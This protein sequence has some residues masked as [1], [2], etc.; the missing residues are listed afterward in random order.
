MFEPIRSF[1][2]PCLKRN[3]LLNEYQLPG[4]T[5][6]VYLR[7]KSMDLMIMNEVFSHRCY[8]V[9]M[10]RSSYFRDYRRIYQ[11][12]KPQFIIDAGAH[13]GLSSV[14]FAW[15]YPQAKIIALEPDA[16]N[17][18][19]LLKNTAPYPN[20]IPVKGAL[21]NKSTFLYIN[22]RWRLHKDGHLKSAEYELSEE[23][24]LHEPKIRSFTLNELIATYQLD[25]VDILKIDIEGCERIIF[26]TDYQPWLSKTKLLLIETHDHKYPFCF[27]TV[28]EALTNYD[29]LYLPENTELKSVL[30]FLLL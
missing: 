19:L 28:M 1:N 15:K 21:W 4:L 29:F 27:K 9:E 14:Y 10:A 5:H 22:N 2:D 13:I 18:Y 16:E 11:I 23:R 12:R 26:Q 24:V 30:M 17:Y 6:P 3:S 7:E 20:I 25:T 8:D